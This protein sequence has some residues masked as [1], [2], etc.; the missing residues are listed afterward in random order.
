MVGE[1]LQRHTLFQWA[2]CVDTIECNDHAHM[3]DLAFF[4]MDDQREVLL[5]LHTEGRAHKG[6]K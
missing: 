3:G 5:D 2:G 1:V 6:M 4:S